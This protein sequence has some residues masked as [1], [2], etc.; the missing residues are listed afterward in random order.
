LLNAVIEYIRY[1][2]EITFYECWECGRYWRALY[3]YPFF[4]YIKYRDLAVLRWNRHI[5][6]H[7]ETCP[8]CIHKMEHG[9]TP[10][11]INIYEEAL[12]ESGHL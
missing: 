1:L 10:E 9:I 6:K 5:E 12:K 2:K 4:E 7:G 8:E 11:W 3:E